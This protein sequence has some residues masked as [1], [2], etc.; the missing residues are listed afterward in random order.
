ML[1]DNV[2]LFSLDLKDNDLEDECA[3]CIEE[4]LQE[5][6]FIEDI[7]VLGNSH[8]SQSKRDTISQECRKNLLIKEYIF[9]Y[10]ERKDHENSKKLNPLENEKSH[11]QNYI[12]DKLV[13]ERTQE[14][15]N[16]LK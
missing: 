12:V 4:L 2:K 1:K 13:L 11:F 7:V 6:Y 3:A 10:L 5:N 14:E 8:I 9:P 16:K 15:I